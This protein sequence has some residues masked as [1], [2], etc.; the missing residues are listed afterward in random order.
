MKSM[1][2][3][4]RGEAGQDGFKI[5]VEV[6]SVNRKQSEI[7]V[8]LPDQLEPLEAQMRDEINRLISRG[9]LVVRVTMHAADTAHAKA[10]INT[11]VAR[12][13]AKEL[14][15]LAKELNISSDL[16]LDALLRAPGVL[17]SAVNVDDAEVFWPAVKKA[18]DGALAGLLKMPTREGKP[19]AGDLRVRI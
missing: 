5:T 17:E 2:G 19:L 10:R 1:T 18:L 7:S 16:T 12:A 8:S 14:R 6:G 9:R 3:H 15:A 13:Y 11:K 4:G